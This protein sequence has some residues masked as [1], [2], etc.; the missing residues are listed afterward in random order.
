MVFSTR[1][2]VEVVQSQLSVAEVYNL[3]DL[4]AGYYQTTENLKIFR[5][6]VS[7]PDL[8]VKVEDS[9]EDV[10]KRTQKVLE[11]MKH[12]GIK[13]PDSPRKDVPNLVNTQI[14]HDEHIG[15]YLLLVAQ[16]R[17]EMKLRAVRQA[18]YNDEIRKFFNN[19]VKTDI[20]NI[21]SITKYLK[22]KGWLRQKPLFPN[23]PKNSKEEIDTAEAFNLWE[24][25]TFRYNNIE[26]TRIFGALAHDGE[27]K[28]LMRQGMS[29]LK[30]Q[31]AALEKEIS[32]FGLEF[33][34]RPP[35]DTGAVQTTE[36]V[37][38]DY[39]FRIM[40]D[41]MLGAIVVHSQAVKTSTTNDRIRKLFAKLLL[42]EIETVDNFL[43]YGKVKGWVFP[44]PLYRM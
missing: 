13:S 39:L 33:P 12:F 28:L 9:I 2:D 10:E 17:L 27:F 8:L 26:Q 44:P 5:N 11:Q 30:R 42:E 4:L 22:L 15:L 35:E 31:T 3:W 43:K 7:D 38:D 36:I 6:Y 16:E 40:L 1:T 32:N 21:D 23:V 37:D 34:K 24:H 41:G 19:L 29:I 18:I 20:N 25:L 14:I